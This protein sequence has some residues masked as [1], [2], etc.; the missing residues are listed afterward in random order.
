MTRLW[1]GG[2]YVKLVEPY[3]SLSFL[4]VSLFM[5]PTIFLLLM[6]MIGVIGSRVFLADRFL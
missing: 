4:S 5:I 1:W 3:L 2:G 6:F